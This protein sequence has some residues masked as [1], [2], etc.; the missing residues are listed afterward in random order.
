MGSYF[1][2]SPPFSTTT[3]QQPQLHQQQNV[4]QRQPIHHVSTPLPVQNILHPMHPLHVQQQHGYPLPPSHEHAGPSSHR[5]NKDDK[6]DGKFI[7][8]LI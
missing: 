6:E 2:A 4:M 7:D 5:H 3:M 8:F 1:Q